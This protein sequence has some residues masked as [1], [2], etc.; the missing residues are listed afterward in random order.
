MLKFVALD[1]IFRGLADPTRRFMVEA[2]CDGEASVSWLAE[3]LPMNFPAILQHLRLL[4]E[5][6]LIHT[7][8]VGRVRTC[9]I[10]PQALKLV[11]EWISE[12]RRV[13]DPRFRGP[14]WM[15]HG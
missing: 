8:K 10:E 3:P 14:S 4:E 13:F 11:D 1:K 6:G 5:S 15:L 7:Q 2:L 9:S 12:R